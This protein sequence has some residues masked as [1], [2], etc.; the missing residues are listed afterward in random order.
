[1]CLS[2]SNV[3]EV[4]VTMSKLYET[5]YVLVNKNTKK[6]VEDYCYIYHYTS[7][8][9]ELNNQVE[10]GCEFIP[11]TELDKTEQLN[12][13]KAIKREKYE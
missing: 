13:I 5:D 4:V 6:P 3:Y 8:I 2:I 7:V 12:Y 10:D 1:M 11:M 9:D